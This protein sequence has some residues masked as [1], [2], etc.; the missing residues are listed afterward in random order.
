MDQYFSVNQELQASSTYEDLIEYKTHILQL[1]N[2]HPTQEISELIKRSWISSLSMLSS[3]QV[4]DT[5]LVLL[6]K[7]LE[8]TRAFILDKGVT[9]PGYSS[10]KEFSGLFLNIVELTSLYKQVLPLPNRGAADITADKEM[11]RAYLEEQL[12]ALESAVQKYTTTDAFGTI[13]RD[14]I[15]SAFAVMQSMA[16]ESVLS[17]K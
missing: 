17:E 16:Q 13:H 9:L 3:E 4:G 6:Y 8:A 5:E 10:L 11:S 7:R 1:L 12:H 14:L 2:S 15:K